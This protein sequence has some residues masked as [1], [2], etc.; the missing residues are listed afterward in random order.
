M[1][2][3]HCHDRGLGLL[4]AAESV[5]PTLMHEGPA[6]RHTLRNLAIDTI[7]VLT[8]TVVRLGLVWTAARTADHHLGLF[9]AA[10]LPAWSQIL[11]N[12]S[13]RLHRILDASLQLLNSASVA[14]SLRQVRRFEPVNAQRIFS[15]APAQHRAAPIPHPSRSTARRCGSTA[16]WSASRPAR[17]SRS[18]G[19]SAGGIASP[20][21]GMVL[22]GS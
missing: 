11:L 12:R 2:S 22:T 9:S 18:M 3:L 6:W 21:S 16:C 10:Q 19:S 14:R 15:T 5:M 4:L 7:Y 20:A 17:R 13:H 8:G 1:P